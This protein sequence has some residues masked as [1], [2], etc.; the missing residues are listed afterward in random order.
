VR[1]K[2]KVNR[3]P[4]SPQFPYIQQNSPP[5][6]CRQG[7][8]HTLQPCVEK[9]RRWQM[10]NSIQ[11]H[12]NPPSPRPDFLPRPSQTTRVIQTNKLI[13]ERRKNICQLGQ[14]LAFIVHLLES[15]LSPFSPGRKR[16]SRNK[17]PGPRSRPQS[18]I[19]DRDAG[20]T[21]LDGG[22][23]QPHSSLS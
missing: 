19:S 4:P 7:S 21:L 20:S 16:R 14:I 22:R 1:V 17:L 13:R 23:D 15:T 10:T 8:L 18:P 3:R 6:L 9:Q 5:R 12:A 11:S 2:S